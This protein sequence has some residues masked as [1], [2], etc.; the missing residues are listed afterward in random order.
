[1]AVVNKDYESDMK[2]YISARSN[3]TMLDKQLKETAV[4][5]SYKVGGGDML[6]FKLK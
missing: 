4:K 6:L 3:V 2:L 5:S 1:M